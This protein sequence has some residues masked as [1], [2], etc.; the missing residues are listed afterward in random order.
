MMSPVLWNH[1]LYDK[2]LPLDAL[3]EGIAP[4]KSTNDCYIMGY[5]MSC[6]L[7]LTLRRAYDMILTILFE[8][9]LGV[10]WLILSLS[11]SSMV[12]IF[13]SHGRVILINLRIDVDGVADWPRMKSEL[14]MINL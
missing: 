9:V 10:E 2:G 12:M 8:M 3:G 13:V 11:N 6:I 5:A 4:S 14:D 7:N 1:R